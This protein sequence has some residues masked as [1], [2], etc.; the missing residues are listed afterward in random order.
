MVNLA[1]KVTPT[2]A[3]LLSTPTPATESKSIVIYLKY[4]EKG[5]TQMEVDS[6]HSKIEQTQSNIDLEVPLDYCRM[7][8]LARKSP[9][10]FRYKYVTHDFFTNYE[11]TQDYQTIRPGCKPGDACVFDVK[12]FKCNGDIFLNSIIGMI[13]VSFLSVVENCHRLI[14][15]HSTPEN[16]PSVQEN[17]TI[18]S[19]LNQLFIMTIMPTMIS[20][21]IYKMCTDF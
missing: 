13:S 18:S 16:C 5:H 20:L 10:P 14:K 17:G 12:E 2:S 21:L 7:I 11:E 4:L 9:M 3:T 15:R 1:L 6:V 19:L 8:S